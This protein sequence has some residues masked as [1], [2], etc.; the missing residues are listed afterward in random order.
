MDNDIEAL[1]RQ[2][3]DYRRL[4]NEAEVA[5]IIVDREGNFNDCNKAYYSLMGYIDKPV[6]GQ[7]HPSDISPLEQPDGSNSTEKARRMIQQVLEQGKCSFEWTHKKL[8]G[9]EFVSYVTL[10]VISFNNEDMIRA[11]IHDIS[12]Q[13]RLDRL[14]KARTK[15]LEI[16][17]RALEHLAKTDWLTGLY[18][19]IYLDETLQQ[20]Q[21]RF[22]RYLNTF[23]VILIDLDYFKQINDTYGHQVGDQ[24]LIEVSKL[25]KQHCRN[26]D[27]VARWG[28]EE[29]LIITPE[30][31]LEGLKVIA[32]NLR[33]NIE[34]YSF[35]QAVTVTASLGISIFR[36]G[37]SVERLIS[38]VDK[39]L[40]KAK[41]KGRNTV[42][43]A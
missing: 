11:S 5:I 26:V 31:N 33:E 15:E 12:E 42:I 30:T 27:T 18:N 20:E 39:A 40:Y 10:D 41:D 2:L 24:V 16:K 35:P 36:K 4:F 25:L 29:F 13:R 14:V 17:N 6:M 37:D 23:G 7:F 8:D 19:R 9:C 21:H 38:R 32:E 3:R 1:E 34:S 28:G 43:E 22:E